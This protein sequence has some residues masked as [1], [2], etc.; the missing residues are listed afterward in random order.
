MS[1]PF[2]YEDDEDPSIT[3]ALKGA[4][5][6]IVALV[7]GTLVEHRILEAIKK[8]LL[9][10]EAELDRF[11]KNYGPLA[12]FSAKNSLGLFLGVYGK[13][14]FKDID[15]IRT[16]RNDFAHSKHPISFESQR[17]RDLCIALRFPER[18]QS[19]DHVAVEASKPVGPIDLSQTRTRFIRA[20]QLICNY[21]IFFSERRPPPPE[22]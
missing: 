22:L 4:D 11:S 17:V 13:E 12:T 16:I 7:Y 19:S 10:H 5:D 1:L 14:I 3:N 15:R 20:C 8:C 21:L 9:A 18:A 2:I 6:R